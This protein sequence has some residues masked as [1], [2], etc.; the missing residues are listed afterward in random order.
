M[1]PKLSLGCTTRTNVS[2]MTNITLFSQVASKLG[3]RSFT[4]PVEEKQTDR[5][6]KG[7]NS[8]PHLVSMPFCRFA[9]SRPARD[10][11]HGLRSA[12][13]SLSRPGAQKAPSK[14]SISCQG[15]DRNREPF[16]PYHYRL[17]SGLKQQT[18]FKQVK[19]TIKSKIFLLGS[20]AIS[21]GL[22]LFDRAKHKTAQGAVRM[23]PLPDFDGNLPA[24]PNITSGKTADSRGAYEV[25]L[26]KGGVTVADRFYNDFSRLSIWHSKGVYSVIRHKENIQ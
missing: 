21:L 9:R 26:L 23:H 24:Y 25:P 3:R 2:P 19:F 4:G 8:W 20:T 7:H 10:I 6:P 14:S 5:R 16:R 22:S 17:L 11:S 13:G 12:T 1:Y 15:K 18:G